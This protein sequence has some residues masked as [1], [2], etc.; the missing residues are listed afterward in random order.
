MT[1]QVGRAGTAAAGHST[2]G[3]RHILAALVAHPLARALALPLALLAFT[4]AVR[5]MSFRFAV[6]DTD[7]GLYLLQ[8]RE[9]LRGGW[10]YVAVWD[11]HPVGAPAMFAAAWT[12]FGKSIMT[13]RLL[14]SL[15][16]AITAWLTWRT[17]REL[18]GPRV[19]AGAASVLYITHSVMLGGLAS[20]TEILFAPFVSGALFLAVRAA[21]RPAEAPRW[22]DL[23]LMG[24]LVGYG[25]T[26]KPVVVPMGCLAFA[27]LVGPAWLAGA[28]GWRRVAAMAAAYTGLC[29]LPTLLFAL[30]YAGR[31][32]FQAFL[33]GSFLAPLTY[34]A[35]P[36]AAGVIWGRVSDSLLELLWLLPLAAVPLW[37]LRRAS[38]ANPATQ[39][40]LVALAWLGASALAVA[41]PGMYFN[42]YFVILLAPLSILAAVGAWRLAWR[43]RP[44]L[45]VPAFAGLVGAVAL[46]AWASDT[47]P[48][49]ER[50]L[51]PDPPRQ[52]AEI[53]R[54]Q[55]RRGEP[56]F[57]ANYHAAVYVMSGAG[58]PTRFAFPG[59]L[60]CGFD[61]I[62][63]V[64]ADAEVNRILAS[65]PRIIVVDRGWWRSMRRR[66]RVNIA[67][68]LQ[69]SYVKVAEVQE[70][71]GM[72]E[73]WRRL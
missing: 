10:P 12:L 59:H 44:G 64:D 19:V 53:I 56:I 35:A 57:V 38:L 72:V 22:R 14:A 23:A 32:E 21:T 42:H 48:R 18:H 1:N 62:T 25:L 58:V 34:A 3:L 46:H 8:A 29:L 30:A 13:V 43:L 15:C 7:E 47:L 70:V 27:L 49:W 33:F 61:K 16:V 50:R 66:V 9:W 2:A 36:P 17:V 54:Q 55:I 68:T 11:M 65:R 28:Q 60:T 24:V 52:V 20:N 5:A 37:G 71:D 39:L 40:V 41:G 67:T 69:R 51:E 6:I 31:G 63:G 73:I 45:A 26:I 4:L